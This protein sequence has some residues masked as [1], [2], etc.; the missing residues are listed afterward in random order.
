MSIVTV[1]TFERTIAWL[2]EQPV[3]A[4][5]LETTGLRLWQD[6]QLCGIAV[7]TASRSHY[8]PF[9]H[10]EGANLPLEY[11]EPL[12]A[13]LC[14]PGVAWRMHNAPFDLTGLR[15]EGFPM[16]WEFGGRIEESMT[17]VHLLNEN[18]INFKLKDL[19][20]K[21][22]NAR[23]SQL[24][25]ELLATIKRRNGKWTKGD[26][27]RLPASEVAAYAARDV[28]LTDGLIRFCEP[29]LQRA[30]MYDLWQEYNA[31]QELL[32]RMHFWG[33]KLDVERIRALQA[34]ASSRATELL[35]TIEHM[36]GY[37]INL[38]SS[39]QVQAWLGVESSAKETL[40]TMSD[41]PGVK[42]LLAYRAWSKANGTYYSKMLDSMD[43]DEVLHPNLHITGTKTSRLSCSNPNLQSL[44]AYSEEYKVKEGIIARPGYKLLMADLSQAEMRVGSHYA[45]EQAMI[46]LLRAGEDIHGRTAEQLSIP[47]HY[48]K[49]IN[50]GILYGI[51][52]PGLAGQLKIPVSEAKE[53]LD[54]YHEAYPGFNQLRVEAERRASTRREIKLFTG[55]R[56]HYNDN[57]YAPTHKAMSN[58]VQ[59]TVG[60]MMRVALMRLDRALQGADAHLFL[61]VHDDVWMEAPDEIAE[62]LAPVVYEA[63]TD[64]P[65]LSVPMAAEVRTGYRVSEAKTLEITKS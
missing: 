27:W 44:P 64:W 51:G 52:A 41:R 30:K 24:E 47:R 39:K 10:A 19:S 32:T 55:R 35:N 12:R 45:R 63:L 60:E 8:M 42:E 46:D 61:Q 22:L 15:R 31:Y 25:D 50:F 4:V 29:L 2:R 9:R 56:R 40:E 37:P 20:D 43:E 49:R 14:R 59:G 17:A 65:W 13:A 18:E 53:I 26:M 16:P 23:S 36:A 7:G 3:I 38:N 48:A 28:Q 33:M 34:E 54:A 1:D 5:D 6:D 11:L 57:R 21:Y 62:S 58:L